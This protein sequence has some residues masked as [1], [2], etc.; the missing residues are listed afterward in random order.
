MHM[1][2]SSPWLRYLR[3]FVPS[4]RFFD[5]VGREATLL[6]RVS[7]DNG[8]WEDWSRAITPPRRGLGSLW[9]NPEGNLALACQGLVEKI[10]QELE[11]VDPEDAEEFSES[12]S[13]RLLRN[14]VES[15]L[16][17]S[18]AR[19]QFKVVLGSPAEEVLVSKVHAVRQ[20][21]A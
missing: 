13:Y 7:D 20:S 19:F 17:G 8:E 5:R 2:V 18:R 14:L 9:V 15:R 10:V 12:L 4:W 1:P 3:A 21:W 6:Y 16:A 11:D